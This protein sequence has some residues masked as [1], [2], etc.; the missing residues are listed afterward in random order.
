MDYEALQV[1]LT[2]VPLHC[3]DQRSD[4]ACCIIKREVSLSQH[5][6]ISD[7]L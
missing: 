7:T 2:F 6:T 1:V 3:P 5:S 4:T